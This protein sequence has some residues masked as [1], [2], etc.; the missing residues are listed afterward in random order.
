MEQS[1][2][3][4]KKLKFPSTVTLL[5]LIILLVAILTFIIPSGSYERKTDEA[6]GKTL[7]VPGSYTVTEKT[8]ITFV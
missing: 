8:P 5:A 3:P 2:K 1:V 7:V 6:L 4:G